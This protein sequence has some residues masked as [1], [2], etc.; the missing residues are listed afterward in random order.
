M[1]TLTKTSLPLLYLISNISLVACLLCTNCTDVVLSFNDATDL[2]SRCEGK[3]IEADICQAIFRTNYLTNK[4]HLNL[5]GTS[6]QIGNS[7]LILLVEDKF[8]DPKRMDVNTTY[9]C[10][11]AVDCAKLFYQLTVRALIENKPILDRRDAVRIVRSNKARCAT[12][13]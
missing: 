13:L 9:T 11:T 4:I 6:D 1:T 10:K 3:P 2:P 8:D 12:V 5:T 7:R